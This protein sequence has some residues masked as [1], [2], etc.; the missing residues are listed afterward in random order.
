MF[1]P[2]VRL[3]FAFRRLLRNICKP[4]MTQETSERQ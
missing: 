4:F 1:G 2:V 3:P